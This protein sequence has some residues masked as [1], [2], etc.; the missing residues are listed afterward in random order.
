MPL[1]NFAGTYETDYYSAALFIVNL[2]LSK[3]TELSTE[4]YKNFDIQLRGYLNTLKE[5]AKV[6]LGALRYLNQI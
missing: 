5:S 6:P 2:L 3:D 4:E 1:Q